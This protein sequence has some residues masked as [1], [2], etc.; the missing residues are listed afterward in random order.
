MILS[1]LN[2]LKVFSKIGR[3][4]IFYEGCEC[5]VCQQ[6]DIKIYHE[7]PVT[8]LRWRYFFPK[9]ALRTHVHSVSMYAWL[10]TAPNNS[11][12]IISAI[13]CTV[14]GVFWRHPP[15]SLEQLPSLRH[16][17]GHHTQHYRRRRCQVRRHLRAVL[18]SLCDHIHYLCFHWCLRGQRQHQGC[19]VSDCY[20]DFSVQLDS[21]SDWWKIAMDINES[22]SLSR[23]RCSED[24]SGQLSFSG[25][26]NWKIRARPLQWPFSCGHQRHVTFAC[27]STSTFV[28][29]FVLSQWWCKRT[30]RE[31]VS[32]HSLHF[33][34][35][36]C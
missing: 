4:L 20:C 11:N 19:D 32:T 13:Y 12:V 22:Q 2:L 18:F 24:T 36:Q 10:L 27:A 35:A 6:M 29:S 34:L 3:C 1:L 16:R 9:T 25:T 28:S 21:N 17:H 14:A 7:P 31:W 33:P 30:R 15:W 8:F 23:T 5:P 26:G